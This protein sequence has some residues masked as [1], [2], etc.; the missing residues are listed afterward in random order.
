MK[1]IYKLF[2]SSQTLEFQ[3]NLKFAICLTL[4][5]FGLIGA[6]SLRAQV[7]PQPYAGWPTNWTFTGLA[8][9][10]TATRYPATGSNGTAGTGT[11]LATTN[12]GPPVSVSSYNT[13]NMSFYGYTAVTAPENAIPNQ[14]SV[15][16]NQTWV[17]AYNV[18]TNSRLTGNGT[19]GITFTA[20]G[21]AATTTNM[22]PSGGYPGSALVALN[23][24]GRT[25]VT[26]NSTGRMLSNLTYNVTTQNRFYILRMQYRVG[27]TGAFTDVPGPVEFT[28]NA[29][30]TSY[31]ANGTTGTMNGNL[32]AECDNQPIVHVRWVYYQAS[33]SAGARAAMGLDEIT[34]SS[35]AVAGATVF[36]NLASIA[37]PNTTVSTSSAEQI[38]DVSALNLTGSSFTVTAPADFEV[39]LTSGSGF[40]IS[41]PV[42]P[43]SGTVPNTS[44]YVR[45]SP[46]TAGLKSGNIVIA[47]SGAT[48][49]NVAVT[50]TGISPITYYSKG[51]GNLEITG[52]W[53]TNTDGTGT[54]PAD[55]TS[56]GQT[57]EIR[58]RATATIGAAWT[59]SGAASKVV[60]GDGSGAVNFTVPSGFAFTGPVDVSGNATLTLQNSTIPTIGTCAAS[61][62]VNFNQSGSFTLPVYTGGKS[63]GNLILQGGTKVLGSTGNVSNQYTVNG[64]LTVDNAT[65]Q[66][67]STPFSFVILAGNLN[68]INSAV[69]DTVTNNGFTITTTGNA[70]QTFTVGAG[71]GRI[72]LF[73]LLSTK[74]AGGITLAAS[75]PLSLSDA[76]TIN[77]TGTATFNDGG[78]TIYDGGNLFLG[79]DSPSR[80][81]LTG[82][83]RL[84]VSSSFTTGPRVADNTGA[85]ACVAH[86]NNVIVSAAAS[87]VSFGFNP[88]TGSGTITIKGVLHFNPGVG[89]LSPQFFGNTYNIGGDLANNRTVAMSLGTSTIKFNGTGAQGFS[90]NLVGPE[91]FNSIT[92]DKPSGN[93]TLNNPASLSGTLTLLTSGNIV[94]ATSSDFLTLSSV[95]SISGGSASSFVSGP[96]AITGVGSG[97][98]SFP[99]GKGTAYR[100]VILSSLSSAGTPVINVEVVNAGSGGFLG[101][102]VTSLNANRYWTFNVTGAALN[103]G[104]IANL[105]YGTDDL[106]ATASAMRVVRS[107]TVA[108]TYDIAGTAAGSANNNGN[109]SSDALP[110]TIG[111][112]TTGTTSAASSPTVTTPTF[113]GVGN[114]NATLGANV[115]SDGGSPVTSRGIVWGLAPSPTGN[116][117][118]ASGTT[119]AFTIPVSGL[120]SGTLIYFRGFATNGIGT[121]YSADGSFTTTGTPPITTKIWNNASGGAWSTGTNWTPSGAPTAG[122]IVQFSTPGTYTVTGVPASLNTG[123]FRVQ[124]GAI[125][126]LQAPAAAALN[127]ANNPGADFFVGAGSSLVLG[128]TFAITLQLAASATGSV[129]GSMTVSGAAHRLLANI[130]GTPNTNLVQFNSGSSFTQGTGFTGNAFGSVLINHNLSVL[131]K[132]GSNY[133]HQDGSNPFGITQPNS[134]ITFEANSNFTFTGAGT[135]GLS[136]RTYG[137]FILNNSTPVTATGAAALVMNSLTLLGTS[138]FNINLTGGVTIRGN[139]TNNSSNGLTFTP[140]SGS[141]LTLGLNP[142]VSISGTGTISTGSNCQVSLNAGSELSLGRNVTFGG[143]V[144]NNGIINLNGFDLTINGTIGGSGNIKGNA[145]STL[146]LGS[147]SGASLNI[148]S[149]QNTFKVLN[150]NRSGATVNVIG[151]IIVLEGV[152]STAGIWN[153]SD[154][155]LRST[156]SATAYIGQLNPPAADVTGTITAERYVAT[157]GWH[158]TG[159]AINGQNIAGWNDDLATQ[160][161]MPGVETPNP[162]YYTSSIFEYDQTNNDVIPYYGNTTNGWVVPSSSAINANQGYRVFIS[163]GTTLDNTGTYTTGTK[164]LTLSSTGGQTYQGYNLVVNPHLSAVNRGS[165]IFGS[166]VQNT[167]LVWDPAV[168]QYRYEGSVVTSPITTSGGP[169]PIASGQGFFLFT[170]TNGSTVQI[171]E[172]AKS[173]SSGTFFRTSASIPGLEIQ[174]EGAGG[175]TDK[176]LFQFVEGSSN[177]YEPEFDAYKLENPGLNIFTLTQNLSKL[178]INALPFEGNQ[179]TIPVGFIAPQGWLK[180]KLIGLSNLVATSSVFLKDNETGEIFDLNQNNLVSFFNSTNGQNLNRFELIFTNS[181]TGTLDLSPAKGVQLVPNP[182]SKGMETHLK[183]SGFESSKAL[184]QIFDAIGKLV[185]SE[186]R[187]LE[188][189]FTQELKLPQFSK[190][191]IYN[192]QVKIGNQSIT[193]KWVVQ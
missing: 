60:V 142:S 115:T 43:S 15:N 161:P 13:A 55:F 99:V 134:A 84:S 30:A 58:N 85:G 170:T 166:G 151:K 6:N 59:V 37:F 3:R 39:S 36:S 157:G 90:S 106:S 179:M 193:Q 173:T 149:L 145:A 101:A 117:N 152:N 8:G 44:V 162:G 144:T 23:T 12:A 119:G 67:N 171:P 131:F 54:S 139:I 93:L 46:G 178:A 32:P 135:P 70:A 75:S 182:S 52:T 163:G 143:G 2:Q 97:T 34:I 124:A 57:F 87:S 107:S 27:T 92:I 68:S 89:T 137:N 185:Y 24:S 42:T 187:N 61:S 128:G 14:V 147:G 73:R 169:S 116:I 94:S 175:E 123:G 35:S 183:I 177:Q 76:L 120:P 10:E 181:I 136:G 164:T 168:N 96:L 189:P 82:T 78:N 31:R 190:S 88:N 133:T 16:H 40:G 53:G 108:G 121:A 48:S 126:T 9:A 50:G 47:G 140:A 100:P 74:S 154:L 114:N 45:F 28:S 105:T 69:F 83:V 56:A 38:L 62:T 19:N 192:V 81:N 91:S 112:L 49:K 165:F 186:N 129:D 64:D 33:G 71:S 176:A 41:V 153:F 22:S 20:V 98:R 188:G 80:Y 17:G 125:V 167:I 127:I 130:T 102:G 103:A 148:N 72:G 5:S 79:G 51:A 25:G 156:A 95:A 158:F 63:F 65:V 159:T 118:N 111:F 77:Y 146:I 174:L 191:G 4:F 104:T 132:N 11:V 160:G 122:D 109:I 138:T 26:V 155:V 150:L 172:S 180:I 18:G 184:L 7:F 113:S 66:A 110:A 21:G 29:T 1:H 86:L 141:A